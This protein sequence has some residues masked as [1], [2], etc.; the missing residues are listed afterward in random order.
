MA[1]ESDEK[2]ESLGQTEY[3]VVRSVEKLFVQR[4]DIFIRYM[5]FHTYPKLLSEPST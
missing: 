4:Q 2:T 1:K 5:F 3:V